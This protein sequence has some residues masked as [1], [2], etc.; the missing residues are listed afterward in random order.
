MLFL[1]VHLAPSS[2]SLSR[3]RA[4]THAFLFHVIEKYPASVFDRIYLLFSSSRW[5]VGPLPVWVTKRAICQSWWMV[6]RRSLCRGNSKV[7]ELDFRKIRSLILLSELYLYIFLFAT[8]YALSLAR[9][10]EI[11]VYKWKIENT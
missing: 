9:R 8:I 7:S 6:A 10:F 2:L 3:A 5:K 11:D 4:H 1:S